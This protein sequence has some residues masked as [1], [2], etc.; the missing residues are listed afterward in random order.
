MGADT[1]PSFDPWLRNLRRDRRGL[2]VPYVNM[3]GTETIE[4]T[5]VAY[6]RNVGMLA[7]FVDEDPHGLPD[8]LKQCRQRQRECMVRGLCQVCARIVPWSRR[9]LPV[10]PNM[11]QNVLVDGRM[12][13][14]FSE[15]WLCE[16]CAD[17]AV[18]WCPALIRRRKEDKLLLVPVT[19]PRQVKLITS[20]GYLDGPL[21]EQTRA[22]PVAMLVKVVPLH[23]DITIVDDSS[24]TE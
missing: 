8:F 23:W 13:A 22:E 5:R 21:H 15:P 20:T 3:W 10:G 18:N 2:P 24:P 19:G 12:R 6:D 4:N 17:I 14:A 9:F 11:G 7:Q 1:R 16:R